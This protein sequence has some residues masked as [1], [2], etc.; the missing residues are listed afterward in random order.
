M[1]TKQLHTEFPNLKIE[2]VGLQTMIQ[3]ILD[4]HGD[5]EQKYEKLIQKH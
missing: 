5:L 4:K 2:C 1:A 3:S